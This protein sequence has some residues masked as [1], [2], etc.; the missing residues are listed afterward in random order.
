MFYTHAQ[1]RTQAFRS[2]HFLG[3]PRVWFQTHKLFGHFVVGPLRQYSHDGQAGFVHG[4]VP[5][6]RKAGVHAA[7]LCQLPELQDRH[8]DGAILPSEAVI[9]HGNVKLVGLRSVLVAQHAVRSTQVCE[10]KSKTDFWM[11]YTTVDITTCL[12][13]YWEKHVR[14]HRWAS[15]K[16]PFAGLVCLLTQCLTFLRHKK[17]KTQDCSF[18]IPNQNRLRLHYAK[19]PL[20]SRGVLWVLCGERFSILNFITLTP[21]V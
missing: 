7:L 16:F 15:S 11:K 6:Q 14:F 17:D 19:R 1:K 3:R 13:S 4:N 20:I 21:D 9:L 10:L 2:R 12:S 18:M 5:D 8:A